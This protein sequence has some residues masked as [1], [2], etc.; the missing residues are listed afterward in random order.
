MK[1]RNFRL[2][3]EKVRRR[4][5]RKLLIFWEDF[6]RAGKGEDFVG[7]L[8]STHWFLNFNGSL[9]RGHIN[10]WELHNKPRQSHKAPLISRR[11]NPLSLFPAFQGTFSLIIEAWHESNMT[12][13]G[14]TVVPMWSQCGPKSG[15][16]V[17]HMLS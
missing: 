15:P 5:G 17:V 2:Q 13:P 3:K 16:D 6:S 12:S 4:A 7:W 10:R 14:K 1:L 8:F 11:V 9:Q